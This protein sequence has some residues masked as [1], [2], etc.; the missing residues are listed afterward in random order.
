MSGAAAD[1]TDALGDMEQ[2]L[3]ELSEE[4]TPEFAKLSDDF[5]TA[6]DSLSG[7]VSEISA[8]LG[9]L[10]DSV[11]DRTD[12]LTEELK[13][14][15]DKLNVITDLIADGAE[16]LNDRNGDLVLDVSDEDIEKTKQGKIE[17]C[18]NSGAVEADR[19]TGGIAG[20]MAIE[21]A[22]DPEDDIERPDTLEFT[23]RTKSILQ[24]CINDGHITGKLDCTGGIV[25]YSTLGTV[26]RCENYGNAES[27]DGDYTGGIAGKS[28]ASVRRCYAKCEIEG[29]RYSGGIAGK[30]NIVSGCCSIAAIDGEENTGAICGRAE[31]AGFDAIKGIDGI[32]S[33]FISFTIRF[34]ADD[35][36][37]EE[38]YVEY[39]SS[40]SEIEYPKAPE[41][42][43]HYGKWQQPD[44][45][46]VTGDIEI[47]CEYSPY[48]TSLESIE[49]NDTGKLPLALAEG[50]F[51]DEAE[52]HI[53][54]GTEEPPEAA[55]TDALVYDIAISGAELRDGDRTKLRL[56]NENKNKAE[57]WLLK[58]GSWEHAE[59]DERGKYIVT[60]ITGDPCTVCIRYTERGFERKWPILGLFVVGGITCVFIAFK[61]K[62]QKSLSLKRDENTS[63]E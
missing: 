33:R 39:G 58:D 6:S 16:N 48:I 26:Y 54:A 13:A 60:E 62:R 44:T 24:S 8:E 34:V 61:K 36:V 56:L 35:E 63:E 20:A 50:S 43:G 52:L 15:G 45:E 46:T 27:T 51:T 14:I 4:N 3:T 47:I 31:P 19:N 28:E 59:A 22:D 17:G 1:I 40:T 2:I 32:P 10:K 25:G 29:K 57:V 23:Y 30:G 7:S 53:T 38:R 37:V 55:G 42:E 9:E 12:T 5:K 11:S 41:K 21:Y 49:R 18:Y